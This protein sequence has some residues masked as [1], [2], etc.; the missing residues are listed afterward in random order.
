AIERPPDH[1]RDVLG[2]AQEYVR[3]GH[4]ILSLRKVAD[5]GY[6]RAL[7]YSALS[8]DETD[9]ELAS[10]RGAY[11]APEPLDLGNSPDEQFDRH[12]HARVKRARLGGHDRTPLRCPVCVGSD[13][14]RAGYTA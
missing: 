1:V 8:G 7:T 14:T 6:E 3:G 4:R 12:R 5:E 11:H 10:D 9:L 2:P 13:G